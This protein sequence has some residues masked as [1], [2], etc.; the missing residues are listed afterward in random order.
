MNKSKVIIKEKRIK[1]SDSITYITKHKGE[2]GICFTMAMGFGVSLA[3]QCGLSLTKVV[4]LVKDIYR[5]T[6][7]VNDDQD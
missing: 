2:D 5:E 1:N 6:E 7:D 3:K 4:D